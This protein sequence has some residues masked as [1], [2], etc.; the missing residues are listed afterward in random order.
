MSPLA[1]I[2]A[3]ANRSLND[4]LLA[5]VIVAGIILF[6]ILAAAETVGPAIV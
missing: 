3:S 5:F 1:E 6:I 2:L 4:G